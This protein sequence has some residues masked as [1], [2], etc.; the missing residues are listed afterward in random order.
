MITSDD[1][2]FLEEYLERMAGERGIRII[3][4]PPD[5]YIALLKEN[6]RLRA[7][8][9]RFHEIEGKYGQELYRALAAEDKLKA[10]RSYLK[11]LGITVPGFRW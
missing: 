4:V 9:K 11:T 8:N 1:L 2:P 7:E 10:L 5:D 6:A 3:T